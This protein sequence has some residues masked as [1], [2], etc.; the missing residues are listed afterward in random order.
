MNRCT[1]CSTARDRN[2]SAS[3]SHASSSSPAAA[4]LRRECDEALCAAYEEL[5]Y[6]AYEESYELTY[7]HIAQVSSSNR[8]VFTHVFA[9]SAS[10]KTSKMKLTDPNRKSSSSALCTTFSS[11][12]FACSECFSQCTAFSINTD[13]MAK[14]TNA[15]ATAHESVCVNDFPDAIAAGAASRQGA[16][17]AG[18]GSSEAR[19]A[20]WRG[21]HEAVRFRESPCRRTKS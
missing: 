5:P 11:V 8:E 20:L 3:S 13:K 21:V 1:W 4:S 12:F 6:A 15:M 17:A 10:S 18:T 2:G 7:G 9:T 16:R 14:T 19:G